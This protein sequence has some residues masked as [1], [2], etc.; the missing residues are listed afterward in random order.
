MSLTYAPKVKNARLQAV[1]D[2]IGP[3]GALQIGERPGMNEV[4]AS[5]KLQSPAFL[6]VSDGVMR[7]AGT[8]LFGS[9]KREGKAA[10]ARIVDAGG[11]A[12]IYDLIVGP[13]GSG[14]DIELGTIDMRPGVD[15]AIMSG[16]II[17]A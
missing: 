13:I 17:H 8:P 7:L 2:A 12:Q 10:T 11:E 14:A 4:L 15:V 9:T 6:V 5:I 1:I 3:A 16:E